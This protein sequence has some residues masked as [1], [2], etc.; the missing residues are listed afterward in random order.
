MLTGPPGFALHAVHAS[1]PVSADRY[2]LGV[3]DRAK[4][5]GHPRR[6]L[7]DIVT[8]CQYSQGSARYSIRL[9]V[10]LALLFSGGPSE[11]IDKRI[12]TIL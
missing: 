9:T 6:T 5:G 11:P 7:Q 1:F 2:F 10:G 4:S 3:S 8:S 12:S